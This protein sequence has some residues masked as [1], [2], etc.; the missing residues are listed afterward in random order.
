MKALFTRI[1]WPVI[2]LVLGSLALA[3]AQAD[4]GQGKKKKGVAELVAALHGTNA[5]LAR[6]DHDYDGHRVKAMEHIHHAVHALTPKKSAASGANAGK[7]QAAAKAPRGKAKPE[8]Q[9]VSDALLKEARQNLTAILQTLEA[10]KGKH[11]LKA[12]AQVQLA[13]E[14]LD[15]ALKIR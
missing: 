12:A 7:G 15:T 2:V 13:I 8:P 10:H 6:A 11:A 1:G 9:A 4:A 5:L 14:E 3:P